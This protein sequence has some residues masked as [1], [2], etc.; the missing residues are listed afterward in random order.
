MARM[1]ASHKVTASLS[2]ISWYVITMNDNVS[3]KKKVVWEP[4]DSCVEISVGL[5]RNWCEI[6]LLEGG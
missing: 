1:E 2:S 4:V 3:S 6:R 5:L